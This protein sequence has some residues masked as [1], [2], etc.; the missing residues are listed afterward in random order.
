MK[1]SDILVEPSEL[2]SSI[3]D[4]KLKIFDATYFMGRPDSEPTAY[5][6]YLLGHIP[7]AGFWDHQLFSDKKSKYPFTLL[8]D[9]LLEEQ[10]GRVGIDN[11]SAVVV[12]SAAGIPWA[13]RAWW[14]LRYAGLSNVRVLNGG[15]AAWQA[16]GGELEQGEVS[17]TPARFTLKPRKAMF[18]GK[19]DVKAAIDRGEVCTLNSL[20]YEAYSKEHIKGSSHSSITAILKAGEG[21]LSCDNIASALSDHL[22]KQ[23]VICYCGGGIAA[24]ANAVG[25]LLAGHENVRVYDGSMSEWSGEN[26]P[27]GP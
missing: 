8:D 4:P 7:S 14:V 27:V 9:E 23:E 10:I 26:L 20:P 16:A 17:Y 12:Y 15:L 2:L 25:C 18:A 13:T 3:G 22:N 5:D 6:Q 19:H 24:T 1:R 11:T 21:Y